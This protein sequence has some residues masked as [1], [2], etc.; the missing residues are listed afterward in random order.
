MRSRLVKSHAFSERTNCVGLHK[1]QKSELL[2]KSQALHLSE[3][4]MP[5]VANHRFTPLGQYNIQDS[6]FKIAF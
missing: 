3:F 4:D 6:R 1:E 5:G 2:K